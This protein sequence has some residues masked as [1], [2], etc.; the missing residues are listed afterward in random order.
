MKDYK[1][2]KDSFSGRLT[3]TTKKRSQLGV[4]FQAVDLLSHH[5]FGFFILIVFT[6]ILL[7]LPLTLTYLLQGISSI[8]DAL[9]QNTQVSLYLTPGLKN[10]ETNELITTIKTRSDTEFV[11]YISPEQGLDQFEKQ[12]GIAKLNDYINNNPIP[13]VIMLKVNLFEPSIDELD[14]LSSELTTLPGVESVALNGQWLTHAVSVISSISTSIAI[15]TAIVFFLIL[16]II[17]GLLNFLLPESL[18]DTSNLTMVYL[19]VLLGI[20]TGIAAD[21]WV[22]YF[23]LLLDRLVGQLTFLNL[24]PDHFH[25]GGWDIFINQF[26]CWVTLIIAALIVRRYH[27]HLNRQR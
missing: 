13:G 23:A 21:Y 11:R 3:S 9:N 2:S 22:S 25:L 17:V 26:G 10:V 19:G 4:L 6:S 15:A 14:E 12:S 20:I 27:R 5:L 8:N 18:E 24:K 16:V 1:S 7:S